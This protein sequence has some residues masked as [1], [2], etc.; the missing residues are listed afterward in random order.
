MLNA[1]SAFISDKERLITIEDAAE[2]QLQQPHVG[3]LETRPPNI[4]GKGEI[5]QR[6]L[7]KNALRMRPD[8]II[9]GECRGE[10]AFDMLQ[11]MNTGHEGSMTTIH[12]N[13]PRDAISRLE[14]M[15]GMAGM[16]MTIA[17]IRAQIASAIRIIVQLQRLTDG[18]RRVISISEITGMEGDVIQ[19]QEIFKYVR[20]GTAADGAVQGH[21]QATG[22]RPRF[23]AD[24]MA[25]GITVPGA[26]FDPSKPL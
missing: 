7:V 19:M 3:R 24:L 2:L 9:V 14:Q 8:R 13:T 4:E 18:K 17:S 5:R 25:Q 1:L 20:T 22:I 16:P 11:A 15:I 6:E 23:L 21:Y 12:A 26:Y 10:E